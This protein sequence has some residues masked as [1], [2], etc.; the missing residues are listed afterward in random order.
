MPMMMVIMAVAMTTVEA[1]TAGAVLGEE[2]AAHPE[3]AAAVRP[4]EAAAVAV[5]LPVAA[6]VDLPVVI[7]VEEMATAGIFCQPPPEVRLPSERTE[8]LNPMKCWPSM[9]A[10]IP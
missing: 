9:R 6:V 7:G 8:D 4:A 1:M 10:K 2:V 3:E 5:D